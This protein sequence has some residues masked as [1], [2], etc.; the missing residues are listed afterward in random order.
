MHLCI[1]PSFI[2]HDHDECQLDESLYL[3]DHHLYGNVLR[4]P[5]GRLE[6]HRESHQQVDDRHQ[7][8]WMDGC[9]SKL[10]REDRQRQ[11]N[12]RDVST[13]LKIKGNSWC[14]FHR[15]KE[16]EK[17]ANEELMNRELI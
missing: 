2:A 14:F 5:D 15:Q 9:D 12:N 10:K 11:A 1:H 4:Q 17:D 16:N 13:S 8:L 6:V 3:D 7:V